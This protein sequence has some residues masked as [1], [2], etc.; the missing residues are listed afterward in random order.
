VEV[1]VLSPLTVRLEG[2]EGRE[3][4]VPVLAKL[5]GSARTLLGVD[6]A[7]LS[8]PDGGG[9][10]IAE[11]FDAEARQIALAWRNA[12]VEATEGR[13]ADLVRTAA[14]VARSEREEL[15]TSM[16]KRIE[17]LQL[18]ASHRYERRRGTASS[19]GSATDQADSSSLPAQPKSG[20]TRIL[21][22]PASLILERPDGEVQEARPGRTRPGRSGLR[23][24]QRDGPTP[25]SRKAP[26]GYTGTEREQVGLAIVRRILDTEDAKLAD[27]RAQRG[28]GADAVDELM[29]FLELKV[30][31]GS[32]PDRIT[33]TASEMKRAATD[34]LFFLVVVANV[35]GPEAKPTVRF[36]VEPL[37][38]LQVLE[39][40]TIALTGVRTSHSL[41]FS[42]STP[43]TAQS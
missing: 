19:S 12:Y 6:R 15:E 26:A 42:F 43:R 36:I 18:E 27:L 37:R 29:G 23:E 39:T 2:I 31:A 9:R 38:Q 22:D 25:V 4:S 33:L 11:V 1:R 41:V 40:E 24:P 13:E 14:E 34:E 30:Y 32:E 8:K 20:S 35:E 28:V 3:L 17:A 21:V 16:A 5:D 10:A 7:A